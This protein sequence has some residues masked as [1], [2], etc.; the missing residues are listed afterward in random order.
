MPK[1]VTTSVITLTRKS[2][3]VAGVLVAFLLLIIGYATGVEG[4]TYA[5]A[6]ILPVTIFCGGFLLT[7]ETIPIRVTLFVIGGV[8]LIAVTL[9]SL[10]GTAVVGMF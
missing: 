5:G 10:T 6:Y 7:E 9:I 3:V 4:V 1:Q 2:A 8:L